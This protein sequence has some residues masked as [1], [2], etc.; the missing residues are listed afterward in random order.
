[1]ALYP[2]AGMTISIGGILADQATDFIATD[3]DSQSWTLVDGWSQM[4]S[5]G[6]AGALITTSIISRGRDV[7][8]KGT[9]SAPSMTNVFAQNTADAGQALLVAA[10]APSNKNNY[11]F[12]I[13]GSDS[14][15]VSASIRYFIGL[16]M[17]TPEAGGSANTIL[18]LNVN[19]QVNSNIVRVAA[20]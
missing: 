13:V 14:L 5:L 2:V 3:F 15:G 1:M 12:K 6:D 17:G 19:I 8:Q 4:G 18:N 20:A 9:A 16:V 7:H 11:A 10:G